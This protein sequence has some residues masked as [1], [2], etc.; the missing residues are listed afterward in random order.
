MLLL[1]L[2][3]ET[4]CPIVNFAKISVNWGQV[5]LN[6]KQVCHFCEKL[7][8]AEKSVISRVFGFLNV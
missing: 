4:A 7:R 2:P 8:S 3:P 1:D 6:E 5:V